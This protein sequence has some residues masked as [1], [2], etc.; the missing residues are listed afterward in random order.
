MKELWV[1]ASDPEARGREEQE[2]TRPLNGLCHQTGPSAMSRGAR[3]SAPSR[4]AGRLGDRR[5][6][7]WPSPSTLPGPLQPGCGRDGSCL[8]PCVLRARDPAPG[9]RSAPRRHRMETLPRPRTTRSPGGSGAAGIVDRVRPEW[10]IGCGRL[11]DH[12]IHIDIDGPKL[13]PAPRPQT[14]PGARPRVA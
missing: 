8:Q 9:T 5:A 11:V 2:A 3:L 10:V 1:G 14:R 4:R 6:A 7:T 12:S 13:P